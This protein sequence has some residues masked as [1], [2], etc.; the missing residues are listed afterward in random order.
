LRSR[1][2]P[3]TLLV[4]CGVVLA[5]A[6]LVVTGLVTDYLRKQ[7][8]DASGAALSHLDAVLGETGN[9]S[10]R[11]IEGLLADVTGRIPFPDIS[12][13]D[14]I[15]RQMREPSVTAHLD[16]RVEAAPQ[17]AGL[18]FIGADGALIRSSG[19]WPMAEADVTGRDYFVALQTEHHLDSFVGAPYVAGHDGKMVIPIARKLRGVGGRFAG[20][21]VAAVPVETFESLYRVVPL[22]DDAVISLVR[23]DGTVLAQYPPQASGARPTA[24]TATALAALAG[25]AQ[26]VFEEDR[27][28]AGPWRIDAIQPFPDYPVAVL[29]SRSGERALVAWYHQLAMFGAFAVFGLIAIGFMVFLIAR[30]FHTHSALTSVRAEKIEAEHARLIAETELMKKERLSVLGQFTATVANELRN[31]LSAIR[32]T[33]FTMRQIALDSGLALDRPIARIQRSIARCDR[34]IGDLLEYT[35]APELTRVPISFDTWLGEV[36]AEHSLPSTVTLIEEFAAGG[37][38]VRIDTERVRRVVINLVDNA[39]QALS[40]MPPGAVSVVTVRSAIFDGVL[41]LAVADTGPGI[42][43]ENMTRIFEPLFSTKSFGTGLGLATAKQ[44]V[45]QHG[46]AISVDSE[47]D[48]GTTITIRLPIEQ[49]MRVAA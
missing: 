27:S 15:A 36:L 20:L 34:I 11:E 1:L 2:R 19:D 33:L 24:V 30:Q 37:A 17:I 42:P 43:R 26:R 44:I 3:V 10:F 12:S 49:E 46:G 13:P 35:R 48:A 45:D 22:T 32:N 31:P 47:P 40:E 16:S 39:A 6:L 14:E 9:R 38:M 41:E 7:T 5:A 23:R 25:G 21:A 18:A 29:V 8:L 28:E 4:V